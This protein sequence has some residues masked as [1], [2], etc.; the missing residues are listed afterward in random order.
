MTDHVVDHLAEIRILK[1]V[2]FITIF[3]LSS[4]IN[5]LEGYRLK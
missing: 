3:I 1:K 2:L 4:P 5:S